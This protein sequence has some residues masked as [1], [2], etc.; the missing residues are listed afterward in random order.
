MGE[1]AKKIGDRGEEIVENF[2]K[3]I[4]WT[5]PQKNIDIPSIYPEKHKKK[6]S[7]SPRRTHGID[8]YFHYRN[9]L[10]DRT[11]DNII[12]SSKF[13]TTKYPSSPLNKFKDYFIDLAWAIESFKKSEIRNQVINN[14]QSINEIFDIGVL[15]WINNNPEGNPVLNNSTL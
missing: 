14:Y 4:G 11:L 9:P 2:L 1:W 3:M 10:I 6:E 12:I 7:D 5:N 13:S 8:L 15:F